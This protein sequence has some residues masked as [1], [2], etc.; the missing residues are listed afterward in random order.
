VVAVAVALDALVVSF[1]SFLLVLTVLVVPVVVA[2][3]VDVVVA[4]VAA[5]DINQ[6]FVQVK[7]Y[8][9]AS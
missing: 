3:A 5:E 8:P 1:A 4:A 6:Y 7:S 9:H 2:V